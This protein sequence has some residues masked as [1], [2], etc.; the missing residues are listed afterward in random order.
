MSLSEAYKNDLT[1]T[2]S[3]LSS[4]LKLQV[5]FLSYQLYYKI[6]QTIYWYMDFMKIQNN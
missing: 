3:K 6:Q 1:F 4:Y 5:T 2:E